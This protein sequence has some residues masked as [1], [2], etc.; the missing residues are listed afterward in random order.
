MGL[1]GPQNGFF[2]WETQHTVGVCFKD[3]S[4]YVRSLK[5]R[6][7]EKVK[8]REY[9]V[10]EMTPFVRSGGGQR[11]EREERVFTT[12]SGGNLRYSATSTGPALLSQCS[13]LLISHH[14]HH[15]RWH[16]VLTTVNKITWSR[17]ITA[18]SYLPSYLSKS[19]LFFSLQNT[20]QSRGYAP[21]RTAFT[22]DYQ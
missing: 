2:R 9:D 5:L 6:V 17:V 20:V 8:G 1:I 21:Y 11:E 16:E 4:L 12:I 14:H 13:L 10:D 18:S 19:L 15:H 7:G 3:H 22:K